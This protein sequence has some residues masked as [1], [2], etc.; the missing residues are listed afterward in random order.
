M[1]K[2]YRLADPTCMVPMPD[3]GGRLFTQSPD[4]ESIDPEDPFYMALIADHDIV[5]VADDPA[6]ATAN[7]PAAEPRGKSKGK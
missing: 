2:R 6:P 1:P 5:E 3:R 4:G 7:Q